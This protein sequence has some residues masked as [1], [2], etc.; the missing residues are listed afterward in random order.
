MIRQPRG[1]GLGGLQVT[2]SRGAYCVPDLQLD[3]LAINGDHACAKL[4]ADCQVVDRLEALVCKLQQ[5]AGLADAC[6]QRSR[7]AG[8]RNACWRFAQRLDLGAPVSPMMMYLNRYL[9]PGRAHEPRAAREVQQAGE[10]AAWSLTRTTS[11]PISAAS[12]A[13][14][15]AL[16]PPEACSRWSGTI[17]G[18]ACRVGPCFR[19]APGQFV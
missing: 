12:R 1:V 14:R 9:R 16:R 18:Y 7:S 4:H 11:C 2:A 3:L 15:R 17:V 10:A 13:R 6:G 5:Q 8:L 19:L